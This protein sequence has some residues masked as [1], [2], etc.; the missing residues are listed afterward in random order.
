MVIIPYYFNGS[1]RWFYN[2]Y[3]DAMALF[4]KFGKPTF[5]IV[6]KFDVNCPEVMTEFK[7]GQTTFDHPDIIFCIYEMKKK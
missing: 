1:D 3:R 2:H 6:K 7:T 4:C 5:L